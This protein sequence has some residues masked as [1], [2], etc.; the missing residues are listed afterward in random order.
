M[1]RLVIS[2]NESVIGGRFYTGV[3][4]LVDSLA[5][6]LVQDYEVTVV[7][8][9]GKGHLANMVANIQQV[10]E[11]VRSCTLMN[12]HY[13]LVQ[14]K[15]LMATTISEIAPDVWLNFGDILLIEYLENRPNKTICGLDQVANTNDKLLSLEKYDT[16]ITLSK[17]Y[18]NLLLSRNDALADLLK[19]KDFH[20][21]STGILTEILSPEKGIL[22]PAK[23]NAWFLSGKDLCKKRFC[24][25]H[26]IPQDRY[27]AVMMGRLVEEK[28]VAGVLE[29]IGNI[30]ESGGFTVI[31]GK[32]KTEYMQQLENLGREDGVLWLRNKASPP[33]MVPMIAGADFLLYPSLME[34]AG[35]MPMTACR[36]G[37]IP[38]TTLNGGLADNMSEDIAIIISN[39][40]QA[41]PLMKTLFENKLALNRKRRVAMCKDFSWKTR[42]QE[43]LDIM[44]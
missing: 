21:V 7:C 17:N 20:G 44:Q 26:G 8:L 40:N 41:A 28:G 38:V 1:K 37:T 34:S 2:S 11:G 35:L 18:A 3:G 25:F 14:D 33:N 36:Y 19:E 29:N 24:E 9:D 43:Y 16:I 6:S 31:A 15:E 23:Y 32:G 30:Y 4:E 13:F 42:K 27:L 10:S 39:M 22:L 12:V 5:I